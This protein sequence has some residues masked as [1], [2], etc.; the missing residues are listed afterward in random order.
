MMKLKVTNKELY[1]LIRDSLIKEII[2]EEIYGATW[3]MQ[4]IAQRLVTDE[5]Y[6]AAEVI[7]NVK[8]KYLKAM[9]EINLIREHKRVVGKDTKALRL[10]KE[11]RDLVQ[12]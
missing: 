11:S 3:L 12:Q 6:E 1:Q 9:T 10:Y 2:K 5:L 8:E 7:S 4:A